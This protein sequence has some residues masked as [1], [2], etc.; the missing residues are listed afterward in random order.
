MT[1]HRPP[2]RDTLLDALFACPLIHSLG[3]SVPTPRAGRPARHP[4]ALHLAWAAYA[5]GI[6]SGNR[7]DA[8][9]AN[10]DLWQ[11]IVERYNAAAEAHPDGVPVRDGIDRLYADT[12][13][14]T[15]DRFCETDTLSGLC[16]SFTALSVPLAQQVGLLDAAGTGSRTRPGALCSIYG[17]GTILRPIYS[18]EE[19]QRRDLDVLT[20][21][22]HDGPV[23]GTK[24][25]HFAVRGPEPHRRV[26]LAVGHVADPGREADRS[27]ELIRSIAVHAPE[28]ISAVIYDGAFRGVHHNTLMTELGLTV[29]NKPHGTRSNRP[30]TLALGTWHH[31]TPGGQCDH[32]LVSHGGSVCDATLDDAGRAVLSDPCERVQVRRYARPGGRYRFSIGVRI[33]CAAGDFVAWISPHPGPGEATT[34]RADQLRLIAPHEDLFAELYGLRNDSEAINSNYKRTHIFDRAPVLGW[35]RQLFDLLA[36]S[37]LNNSIAWWHHAPG[38]ATSRIAA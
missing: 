28:T 2:T 33:P 11:R 17:D 18:G 29:I 36:W 35:K 26:M 13:R 3:A 34:G 1:R 8:E 12:H 24:L 23:A 21:H 4:A 15:R 27:V 22:R 30:K 31:D 6:G 19:G 5:R 20:H 32:A 37:I 25:V 10:N 38:A 7:L 16:S 14:H 9:L